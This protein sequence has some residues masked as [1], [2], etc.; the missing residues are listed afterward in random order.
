MGPMS[1]GV[2]IPPRPKP[3]RKPIEAIHAQDRRRVQNRVAQRNFRD[4]RQMKLTEAQEELAR[5][6]LER[7]AEKA[8]LARERE[9]VRQQLI[10]ANERAEAE[11]QQSNARILALEQQL[12]ALQQVSNGRGNLPG[13]FIRTR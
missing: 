13:H 7:E 8:E 5:I 9:D 1:A 11:R 3:G 10:Q 12:R 4:K 2:T 6:Q